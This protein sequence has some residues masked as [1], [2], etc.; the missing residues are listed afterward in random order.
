MGEVPRTHMGKAAALN[1]IA[2]LAATTMT[3]LLTGY[4]VDGAET[5]ILCYTS[6]A[7][8]ALGIPLVFYK[9]GF[10]K[11]HLANLP[12]RTDFDSKNQ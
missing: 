5:Q 6:A 12:I 4:Y 11:Q 8:T 1:R 9:G 10:M 3:P 7:I 2:Q